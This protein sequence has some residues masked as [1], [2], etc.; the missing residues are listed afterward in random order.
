MF[1]I[2]FAEVILILLVAFLVVGP[3]DLPKVARSLARFVKTL[4]R[5]YQEFKDETGLEE[6]IEELKGAQEDI[7]STFREADPTRE[8]NDA[9]RELNKAL[10]ESKEKAQA[11]LKEPKGKE[12]GK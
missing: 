4:R 3:K 8:V 7:Q 9:K 2:G 1:N 11:G 12:V 6:T 5:M 10:K